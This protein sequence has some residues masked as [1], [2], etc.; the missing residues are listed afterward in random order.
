MSVYWI[1]TGIMWVCIIVNIVS[2][3]QLRRLRKRL[4]AMIKLFETTVNELERLRDLWFEKVQ[5]FS[6]D[7]NKDKPTE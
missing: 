4:K 2:L 6:D 7:G 3:L 1:S 5:E